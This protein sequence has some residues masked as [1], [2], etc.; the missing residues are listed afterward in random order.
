MNYIQLIEF[1]K[2]ERINRIEEMKRIYKIY[3]PW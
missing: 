2:Q 3:Y 1:V